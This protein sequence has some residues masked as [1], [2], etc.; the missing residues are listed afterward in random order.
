M[1][2]LNSFLHQGELLLANDRNEVFG[3]AILEQ[4]DF[5]IARTTKVGCDK[6]LNRRLGS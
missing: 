4:D 5:A 6:L 1:P 3:E 2:S